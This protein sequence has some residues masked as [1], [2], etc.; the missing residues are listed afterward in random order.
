MKPGEAKQLINDLKARG[1]RQVENRLVTPTEAKQ[2]NLQPEKKPRCK[3]KIRTYDTNDYLNIQNKAKYCDQF[4]RLLE[5]ELG[6]TVWP[7]YRFSAEKGYKLD[8]AIPEY[9]L[10]IECDGGIHKKGKSGH[11]S[12]TGIQ[13][14]INKSSLLAANGWLLIRRTPQQ[15]ITAETIDLIKRAISSKLTESTKM[16]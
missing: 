11:S 8:Y 16:L 15:L 10:G 4:T 1:W 3:R 13:R 14:D 2:L 12:G 9:K 6:L 7:E 5:I